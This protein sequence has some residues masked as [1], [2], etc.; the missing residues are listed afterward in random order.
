MNPITVTPLYAAIVALIFVALSIRTLS[1]RRRLGVAIGDGEQ[2]VL[3][4]AVRVHANFAEYVPI[5][6]LLVFL[7]ELG[8]DSKAWVHALCAMLL[9]GRLSHAYGVSQ[10][11]EN[12]RYRVFGMALTFTVIISASLRLVVAYLN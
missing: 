3:M 1:L 6:L 12:Y 5:A 7:L 9:V 4:R 2:A 10:I 8:T 11:E